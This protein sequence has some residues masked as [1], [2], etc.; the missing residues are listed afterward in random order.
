MGGVGLASVV[1]VLEQM[2]VVWHFLEIARGVI[3]DSRHGTYR[4]GI[5]S[6]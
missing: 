4:V 1:W 2:A 3:L 5:L 6:C